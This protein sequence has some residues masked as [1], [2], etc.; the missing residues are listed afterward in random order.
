MN[1]LL[2]LGIIIEFTRLEALEA[3]I[4]LPLSLP[5]SMILELRNGGNYLLCINREEPYRLLS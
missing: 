3:V 1:W 4:T 2:L 5:K